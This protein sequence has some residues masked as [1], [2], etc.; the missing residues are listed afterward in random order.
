MA[1]QPDREKVFTEALLTRL[2]P[3]AK[4]YEVHDRKVPGL[5]V[6][7]TPNGHKSFCVV[8]RA[9]GGAMER[10]TLG[11]FP[12][13]KLKGARDNAKG[14]VGR[15]AA[16]GNPADDRRQM[17]AESTLGELWEKFLALHA[18]PRK[19]S[20][21]TDQRRWK[22]HLSGHAGERA[23]S[24]TTPKVAA[25]LADVAASSGSGA[26]NRVRALL[27]TMFEK[28]RKEWGLNVP[29]PVR[30]TP[31]NPEESRERYLLPDELRAFLKAV[32]AE[33]DPDTRAWLT[34]ALF[35]AQRRGALCRMKWADLNLAD[36]AWS[37][38]AADMKAGRPLLVPLARHVVE[39]LRT[40]R[41]AFESE[42]VYVF[43]SHRPEG[44][45]VPPYAG[46]DRVLKAAEIARCTP[47]DLRRSWATWAQDAG[48]PLEV[49]GRVLG[50]TPQ[51]GVTSVYAR[52]PFDTLRRW[53]D[54][55]AENMLR[56]A[57]APAD[58]ALLRFPGAT[59]E[60][61]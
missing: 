25:L 24:F 3:E 11:P 61:R 26:A 41:A 46:L 2:K 36:A 57:A 44:F 17:R 1:R 33:P 52:V 42:A 47:H 10:V 29:N 56:V 7:V 18:K 12:A 51:G 15:F 31:R 20:W 21:E 49:I 19:R 34:L 59:V 54:K 22:L 28:G 27:F 13:L 16:G 6:R 53:V 8:Y 30:D 5:R 60:A 35:T 39:L 23:R 45:S 58:G 38:P 37:I 14:I 55:T 43:P 50:H 4:R 9:R 48:A 40:R 32:D